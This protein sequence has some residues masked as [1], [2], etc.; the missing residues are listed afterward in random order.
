MT[1]IFV[2][3]ELDEN[4][5]YTNLS[6]MRKAALNNNI[7]FWNIVTGGNRHVLD[8]GEFGEYYGR[9]ESGA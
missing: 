7:P 3:R 1:V 2:F 4:S 9:F 6:A 8:L 5:M